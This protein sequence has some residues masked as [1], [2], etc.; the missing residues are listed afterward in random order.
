NAILVLGGAPMPGDSIYMLLPAGVH[1]VAGSYLPGT[2][3]PGG[4]P[5]VTAQGLQLPLPAGLSAFSELRFSFSLRYDDAAGCSDQAVLLQTRQQSQAFCPLTNQNCSV[6][7]ATGEAILFLPTENA[8]L[9]IKDFA[10]TAA[11]TGITYQAVL[12]NA[13]TGNAHNP[14][15]QFFLDLNHN[16]KKEANE[17][18]VGT[19]QTAGT[20][21]P[22]MVLVITGTL[23]MTPAQLCDLAALIPA[24][25]NCA[26]ADRVLPLGA[27][28]T[29]IQD[30]GFCGLATVPLQ[31]DSV[32]GSTYTWLNPQGLA[33][34]TCTQTTY[35]PPAGT[36]T[37]ALIT[38]VL[39]EKTANC[40]IQ[41]QFNV[42][43][44]GMLGI[45][46]EDQ[47][48]CQGRSV[49]L[50]AS[51]GGTYNWSGPG[52]TNPSLAVQVLQPQQTANYAITVTFADGCTGTDQVA[53]TVLSRDSVDLGTITTCPG[54]PVSIFGKLTDVPGVYS[55]ILPK[56]NGCDSV[57]YRRL[58]LTPTATSELRPLCQGDSTMVF[59]SLFHAPGSLC[60][61]FFSTTGC[62]STHCV[63][64]ISVANPAIPAQDSV[65]IQVGEEVTLEGPGGY[66]SYVWLPTAGLSC[67]D[68][69]SPLAQPDSTTNYLLVVADDHG[70]LGSVLYRV[71]VFPPCDPHR[72]LIPN[73]FT[74]N[75]DGL[76][77]VFSVVP[78][79]GLESVVELSIYD[80]WGAKVYVGSGG[81]AR[82]DGTI[83]GKPAPSDVYV[84]RLVVDC[85]GQKMPLTMEVTLLR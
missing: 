17:P 58:L 67:S 80:R 62:D 57:L 74:P 40:T 78:F 6:Y 29:I 41:H 66:V 43:F 28:A 82:W 71:L 34:S 5:Q 12:E 18:L 37:G 85:A 63:T 1:F 44:G 36:Q 30:L 69:S 27:H 16:G 68:C 54:K 25:A 48:V 53:V 4:P 49:Q 24:D 42:Q 22:A 81:A 73:A 26:C 39:E 70:C 72:L 32:S 13:G 10:A 52:I 65:I 45:V 76:N 14:V 35:T 77:D 9:L 56:A 51:P 47:T 83:N 50:E 15:V 21:S 84:Y 59:D 3:A 79:E 2:N 38:L 46:T 75:G 23:Q 20:L 8:D 33:C 11:G 31:V 55:Q 64:V 60:K 61:T 19:Q 7:V